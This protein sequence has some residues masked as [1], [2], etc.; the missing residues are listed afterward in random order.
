MA[1]FGVYRGQI[2]DTNDPTGSGRVKVRVPQ[3][4]GVNAWAPV[5]YSCNG[6]WGITVGSA[7]IVAFEGGDL[8][9]PVVL[10]QIDG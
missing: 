5:C 3:I 2:T 6:G 7:A 1:M 9:R 10:G 8:N 4:G